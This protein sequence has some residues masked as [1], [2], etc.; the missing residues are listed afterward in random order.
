MPWSMASWLS[1]PPFGH[2]LFSY[3]EAGDARSGGREGVAQRLGLHIVIVVE[4]EL[5]NR[6][7]KAL[8]PSLSFLAQHARPAH[9]FGLIPLVGL[10]P[11]GSAI[12]CALRGDIVPQTDIAYRPET[13]LDLPAELK[14]LGEIVALLL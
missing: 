14:D 5:S 9:E 3:L 2:V 7:D 10:V 1:S 13:I 8:G 4:N 11:L 6:S 12:F